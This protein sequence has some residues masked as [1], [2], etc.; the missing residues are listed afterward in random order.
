MVA[1]RAQLDALVHP[2]VRLPGGPLRARGRD[3]EHLGRVPA[4][5]RADEARARSREVVMPGAS[6]MRGVTGF[7]ALDAVNGAL[8]QLIPDRVPAPRA[9]A[10]TRSRSSAPS[11]ADG[12]ALHLLRARR[13]HL[14][15]HAAR[16]TATTALT[17]PASLAA[18][19]PVEVAE[20]EF[21]IRDR[22][23]RPRARLAAAP[24]STAAGSRSSAS[25]A[26]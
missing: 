1:R 6:S 25:G 24:A 2:G 21:P 14:G 8:A 22:A 10:A 15:R 13:R 17:N 3:P 7:R 26:A 18:N 20:S 4:D 19:I 12:V 23:L 11:G 16:T 9:R 5:P